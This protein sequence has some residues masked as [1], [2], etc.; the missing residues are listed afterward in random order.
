MRVGTQPR[1]LPGY[2]T[3]IFADAAAE[4]VRRNLSRPFFLFVPFNA[5]HVPNPRNKAVGQQV[6][7]QAPPEFFRMYGYDHESDVPEHGYHAVIT[8][9][10]AGVG[11][12]LDELEATGVANRTLVML[13]S[14]NGGWVGPRKPRLETASNA[15]FRDGRTSLYEGGVRTPCIIRWPGLLPGNSVVRE[16]LVN[17]DLFMLALRAAGAKPPQDRVIDGRDPMP[18]L[19]DGARS[20]HRNIYFT[21]RNVRALRQGRWKAVRPKPDSEVE[22]YDLSTDPAESRNL[23]AERP[24]MAAKLWLEF[25]HWEQSLAAQD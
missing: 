16:P 19:R 15:P 2:S 3:D 6:R 18:V 17:I 8:A 5:A 4:F 23:S 24:Q 9:L 21:Y 10:D 1:R 12:V 14:D 13:A 11:R 20:P 25:E 22:L 7:W